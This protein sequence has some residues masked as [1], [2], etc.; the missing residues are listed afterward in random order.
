MAAFASKLAVGTACGMYQRRRKRERKR[1]RCGI[2]TRW[3]R[4]SYGRA[5]RSRRYRLSSRRQ[6]ATIHSLSAFAIKFSTKLAC[7]VVGRV[8]FGWFARRSSVIVP[9]FS[10]ASSR[11]VIRLR[12]FRVATCN[13]V[14]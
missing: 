3:P 7:E 14:I 1:E 11:N 5:G 2:G 6:P 9:A 8:C 10:T 4:T 12:Q 13:P